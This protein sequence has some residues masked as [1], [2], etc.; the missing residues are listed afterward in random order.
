MEKLETKLKSLP[1]EPGIYEMLDEKGKIIY[2]GKAVNLKNRVSSYFKG[3]KDS[4]TTALVEKIRDI[5]WTITGN[6]MEALILESNLIKENKPKYNIILRDDKHYPYLKINLNDKYPKIQVV[7]RKTNDGAIYFGPYATIGGVKGILKLIESIFPLRTCSDNELKHRSR[8]CLQYQ[9]KRC[10]APCVKFTTPEEYKQLVEEAVMFLRGKE[11]ELVRSLKQKMTDYSKN[12]EFEKAGKVRDQIEVISKLTASQIIDK[13][14]AKER[15]VIGLYEGEKKTSVM[16]LFIRDGNIINKENY[17]LEHQLDESK[18]DLLKAFL[19]QYYL[20]HIPGKEILLPLSF[21]LQK[22]QEYLSYLK[23]N[24][25]SLLIPQKGEKKQLVDF[26]NINALE[27]YRQK[28]EVRLM[29]EK[30]LEEGLVNLKKYL[31]L[32]NE[33][34]RIECYDISN[35]SGTNIVASMVVFT[36][37]VADK[38]E[39]KKFKIRTVEGQNDFKS[40]EEVLT[41]RFKIKDLPKPD[42]VLIDGG[43][44]QL[45][46]ALKIMKGYGIEDIDVLGLAKKEELLFKE[47]QS[48]GIFI[49]RGD[50]ALHIMTSIRDEAHRF[51][52]TYHRNLRDKEMISSVFD[53]IEGIG[54]KRKKL[55]LKEFGSVGGIRKANINDIINVL[56]NEKLARKIK[57]VIGDE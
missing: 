50:K 1:A 10:L 36:D 32:N 8:P 52:I 43:K 48:E 56:G 20:N 25:V 23:G 37:G 47:D 7:R 30:E 38:K 45:S 54:P 29:K 33:P 22:T 11:R 5:N 17:F 13:G 28:E 9:I 2:V 16:I 27:K 34:K 26:A 24:K 57:D 14:H 19:E 40:M 6:E 51:A 44:G 35:I 21:D 42:L 55:L 49:P 15:D 46:S 41:R 31:D 4:K 12:M 53:E 39:Y 3:V 18:E